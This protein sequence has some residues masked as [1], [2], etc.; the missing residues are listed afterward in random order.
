MYGGALALDER[1]AMAFD[2]ADYDE[3]CETTDEHEAGGLLENGW[4]L[5]DERAEE[6]DT[7]SLRERPRVS[8][9]GALK[10]IQGPTLAV[11]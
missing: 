5:L 11:S 4:Q 8:C 1:E 2:P 3:V 7:I 10:P 9:V 6:L